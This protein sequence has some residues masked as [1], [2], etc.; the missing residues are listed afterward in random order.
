MKPPLN[1]TKPGRLAQWLGFGL[2][3][4]IFYAMLAAMVLLASFVLLQRGITPDLPW[5]APVQEYLYKKATRS[6]WQHKIDCVD[7]DEEVIYKPKLGACNFSNVEFSTTLNFTAEGR[8]TGQKK[9][10]GTGIAVIGDSHAMGWGVEDE[11]TFAAELERLSNRP[12][13]NLAVSSYGTVRELV[14]LEKSGLIDKIDTIII[15]YCANDLDE[16]RRNQINGADENR[17]KFERITRNQKSLTGPMRLF[18]K[19]Y[20]FAFSYPYKQLRKKDNAKSLADFSPH[21]EALM[22]VLEKHPIIQNK[23]VLFFYNNGHGPRFQGFPV[24]KDK[25]LQNVEFIDIQIPDSDYYRFDDHMKPSGQHKT[26][27]QLFKLLQTRN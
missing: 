27:Q 13:Y 18:F 6:I 21:Y 2:I 12:V 24:G 15:Q 17:K 26:A 10:A 3:A 22:P 11:E 25:K 4:L 20:R 14:R 23:R 9:P 1:S 5:I 8:N 16:N 19:A 7:F